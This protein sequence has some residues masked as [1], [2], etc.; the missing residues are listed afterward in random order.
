MEIVKEKEKRLKKS[1]HSLRDI[2]KWI[3]I[4]VLKEF[5]KKRRKD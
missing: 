5:P 1:E 2:N 4:Y 3:N